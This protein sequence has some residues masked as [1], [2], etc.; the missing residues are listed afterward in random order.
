V[1]SPTGAALTFRLEPHF[2]ETSWFI[3]L[4]VTLA[5]AGGTGAWRL[6]VHGL[7]VR[8]REL[9]VL[10]EERTHALQEERDRA[11]AA[12]R[13]AERADR[14]KSEFLANMSHEIRTPMNAVIGMT[15]VLLDAPLSPEQRQ[16]VDTIRASGEALLGIL[17]DILDFSKVE[18]GALEIEAM[19]F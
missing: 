18:A 5:I 6:R 16:H 14:A 9:L 1:W 2:Y 12:R 10:V 8:E 11:E 13:E 17:N 19:P 4:C 15:S 3:V 7:R